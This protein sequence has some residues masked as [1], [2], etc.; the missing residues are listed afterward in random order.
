VY[1]FINPET[2]HRILYPE[3]S[4]ERINL[5]ID[6]FNNGKPTD[7]VLRMTRDIAEGFIDRSKG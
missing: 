5:I 2:Q 7:E 1:E 3:G 4:G 6:I